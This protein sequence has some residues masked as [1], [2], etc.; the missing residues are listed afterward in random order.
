MRVLG[1]VPECQ[2]AGRARPMGQRGARFHGIRDQTLLNN[3][4][5]NNYVRFLK[6][7]ID[8]ASCNRPVERHIV[9]DAG[10]DLWRS[11][12]FRLFRVD[13]CR[14]RLVVH[15]NQI[16]GVRRLIRSFSNNGGHDV[17]NVTDHIFRDAWIWRDLEIRVGNQPGARHRIQ[18]AFDVRSGKRSDDTRRGLGAAYVDAFD[19]CV[20]MRAAK[21]DHVH[22]AG[23]RVIVGVCRRAGN[24]PGILAP[25]DSGA[26]YSCAH[27]FLLMAAAS[28]TAR[29][30]F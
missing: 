9:L 8:V 22:H 3:P 19:P 11:R 5:L 30:I 27:P 25:P 13:H 29:T 1:R 21:K 28:R 18:R 12:L 7:A 20:R 4:L 6:S 10:V 14:K 15:G 24:K 23:K 2:F 17:T 26:K 16:Q